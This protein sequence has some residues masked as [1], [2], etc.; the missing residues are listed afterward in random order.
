MLTLESLKDWLL[1]INVISPTDYNRRKY[2]TFLF[3]PQSP[4]DSGF[5]RGPYS[6]SIDSLVFEAINELEK[7]FS[8][9]KNRRYVMGKSGGGYGTW[10]FISTHPEMF[11][12][13][14]PICGGGD[15]KYAPYLTDVAIWAFH[16]EKDKLVPVK[17]SRDMIEAIKKA[18][19]N[20]RYT[21]FSGKGHSIWGEVKATPGLFKW[22]FEQKRDKQK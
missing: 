17:L 7:E 13:A 8:I 4:K 22:L 3:V 12:A 20:P 15:P 6:P 9:D 1:V 14:I 19:G 5:G 10:N 11:A 18:G 2:P 16:G 21:E